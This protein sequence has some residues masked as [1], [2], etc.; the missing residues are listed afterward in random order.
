[1]NKMKESWLVQRLL[2]PFKT[3]NKLNAIA[4]AFSFG[5]GYVNGGLSDE[6]MVLLKDIFR[7]DYMGSAEFEFGAVPEALSKIA[8]GAHEKEYV[9]FRIPV[10]YS[11]KDWRSKDVKK[12]VRDVF[13][14]CNKADELEVTAR[15]NVFATDKHHH[16]KELVGFNS[17]LAEAEYSNKTI[18]WLELDNGY[19][20]FKEK[21]CFEKMANLLGIKE[22]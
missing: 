6:A 20:F 22:G 8:K 21:D 15:V 3:E 1:M 16:T 2:A 5:G 11:W 18:A 10:H 14:I 4:N 7:F 19:M 12:G 13:V 9:A 17:S